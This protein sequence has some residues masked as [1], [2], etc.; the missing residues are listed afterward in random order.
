MNIRPFNPIDNEY[1]NLV[2]L[3][4]AIWHEDPTTV[5]S[6]K[7][8]DKNRNP[9]YFHQRV[10][11]ED[12]GQIVG[13]GAYFETAWSYQPGKYGIDF[14]IHPDYDDSGLD[15]HIYETFMDALAKRTPAPIKLLTDAR[16][17]KVDRVR[18]LAGA[19]FH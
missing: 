2:A 11:A 17:D 8:G 3:H 7:H 15:A 16:E 4:N 6:W 13:Y 9:K 1:E 18:F 14:D 12:A 19:W 10:V 5:E